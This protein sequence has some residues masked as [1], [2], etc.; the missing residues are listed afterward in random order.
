ML[1]FLY[2]LL[3]VLI[4]LL[5]CPIGQIIEKKHFNNGCC[6]E[7]GTKLRCFATDSQGARGY[8]CDACG[9]HTWV[10]YDSVDKKFR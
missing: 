8:T 7:C 3:V 9:Y 4:V 5:I 10:S 1:N 6:P 2:A